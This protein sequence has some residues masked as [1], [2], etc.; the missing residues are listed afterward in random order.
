MTQL[1]AH[2]M[3]DKTGYMPPA[4][5]QWDKENGGQFA[6]INVAGSGPLWGSLDSQIAA[7]VDANDNGPDDC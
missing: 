6:G 2:D 7:Y 1:G 4:I 5:W 3:R